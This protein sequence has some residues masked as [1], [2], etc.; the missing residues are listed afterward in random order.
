MPVLD[1]HSVGQK[2][3]L[4]VENPKC[5]QDLRVVVVAVVIAC[6]ENESISLTDPFHR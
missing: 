1:F 4:S 6:Y 5:E 3:H 2:L